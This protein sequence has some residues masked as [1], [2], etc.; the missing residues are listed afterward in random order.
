MNTFFPNFLKR[1]GTS[2]QVLKPIYSG[3]LVCATVLTG[4][5]APLAQASQVDSNSPEEIVQ[6]RKPVTLTGRVIDSQGDAVISASIYLKKR[7]NQR[8]PHGYQW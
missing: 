8:Y 3:L 1:E 4:L 6:N 5:N 2:R 7:Q